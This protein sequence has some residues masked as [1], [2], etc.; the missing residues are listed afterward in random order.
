MSGAYLLSGGNKPSY[1]LDFNEKLIE[2]L[3][4]YNDSFGG[5]K[6]GSRDN[7]TNLSSGSG[8]KEPDDEEARRKHYDKMSDDQLIKSKKTYEKL[9]DQHQKKLADYQRDP[10]RCDNKNLLT[11][12]SEMNAPKIIEGRVNNLLKQITSQKKSLDIIE[13]L[14]GER[15]WKLN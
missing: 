15:G 7:G 9:I 8:D 2:Q 12:A 1:N 13:V 4:N 6:S 14:L 10:L 5:Q 11:E 3:V